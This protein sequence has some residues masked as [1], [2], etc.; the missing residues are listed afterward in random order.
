MFVYK[1]PAASTL[2]VAPEIKLAPGDKRKQTADE[3]W[4]DTNRKVNTQF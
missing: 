1:L 3:T 4:K 2:R